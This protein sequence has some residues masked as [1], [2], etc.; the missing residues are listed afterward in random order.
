MGSFGFLDLK[1]DHWLIFLQ[2]AGESCSKRFCLGSQHPPLAFQVSGTSSEVF[3]TQHHPPLGTWRDPADHLPSQA[4][5]LPP[6]DPPIKK[7]PKHHH[8][9]KSRAFLTHWAEAFPLAGSG[10]S[11]SLPTSLTASPMGSESPY[12]YP[13]GTQTKA[14]ETQPTIKHDASQ[15]TK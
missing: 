5:G 11:L 13:S 15:Q 8:R 3:A 14:E 6:Q 10:E 7:P 9:G 4:G 1:L 2:S 12:P